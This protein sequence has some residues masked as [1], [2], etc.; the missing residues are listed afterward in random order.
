MKMML[1]FSICSVVLSLSSCS[2]LNKT[3]LYSSLGGAALGGVVGKEL[4]PDK[5]SN[6][7]N[8]VLG[9][10]LGAALTSAL[11]YFFYQDARPSLRFKDSP[12]PEDLPPVPILDDSFGLD[13]INIK[14]KIIPTGGKEY[15]QYAN[16]PEDLK[17]SAKKQYFKRYQT[18]SYSF[19]QNGKTYQIPSFEIIENGVE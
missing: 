8:M 12:L 17:K 3:L 19:D 2:T 7:F 16:I 4:S 1:K 14:P 15:L 9:A 13:K 10:T 18:E 6:N 11:G 5:D